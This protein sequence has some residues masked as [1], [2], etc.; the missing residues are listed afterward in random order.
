MGAGDTS[1]PSAR[2]RGHSGLKWAAS[3]TVIG[4]V[5]IAIG[6]YLF[7]ER[8]GDWIKRQVVETA[9]QQGVILQVD[10]VEV[11]FNAIHFREARASFE[12][13]AGLTAYLQ[14]VDIGI[15][16]FKPQHIQIAGLIVQAVG[17]PIQLMNAMWAWRSRHPAQA[18]SSVTPKTEI[19]RTKLLWQES[20]SASPFM[21][22]DD[23]T[24]GAIAKPYGPLGNDFSIEAERAQ[25]GAFSLAP[26]AAAVHAEPESIEIGLGAT[27][28][29]GV[30]ARGGWNNWLNADELHVSFGPLKLGPLLARSPLVVADPTLSTA[31]LV[32]GLSLLIPKDERRAYHGQW[33][34]DV[35]GWAPPHPPELQ[36]FSFGTST[37]LE[38]AF[39]VDRALTTVNFTNTH[40]V[41]GEFK[42]EGRGVARRGTPTSARVQAELKGHIPCAALASAISS[43]KLGQAYGQWVARHAG[44]LVQGNVEVTV[45]IDA[46]T[47]KL[48]QAKVAKQI[49]VGCGLKPLTVGDM[50]ALGLP[51]LPDAD[52][53]R[54]L[55]KDLPAWGEPLPLLLSPKLPDLQPPTWMKPMSH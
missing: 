53:I 54:H 43:S 25:A 44:Q 33:A 30:T 2:Q 5:A 41:S 36:G 9:L 14:G 28:W 51:P 27:Q 12:G 35:T 45:Q 42:L 7:W 34:I 22:L 26:F 46:D 55:G 40:V 20:A 16:G 23:V 21:V 48:H 49:G 39:D 15:S 24:F 29:E 31:T 1:T 6:A 10:T 52:L 13:V 32:G 3:A 37:R 50:L 4:L 17:S 18:S 47:A 11:A 19:K 38:S 8:L